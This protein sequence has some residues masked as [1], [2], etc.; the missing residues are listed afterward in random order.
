MNFIL[1]N[2][3]AEDP[4][5][6]FHTWKKGIARQPAFLDDYS[7]LV[8]ALIHLQEITG[9]PGY[10]LKAKSITEFVIDN[11][12]EPDTGYFYFTSHN[13][14]DV[15]VRKKEVYDGAQPS[16]NAVMAENLYRLSFYFDISLWKKQAFRITESLGKAIINYPSSFGAWSCLYLEM[17]MGTNE[18]VVIENENESL[19]NQ[20]LV[21]Y[22]PH[23]ILKN[24]KGDEKLFP[25]MAEKN[26]FDKPAIYLC[27]NS[28]CEK[29]VETINELMGL[30]MAN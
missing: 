19:Y 30:I 28:A 12:S 27:R 7:F 6:F 25:I 21:K 24:S 18:I 1:K 17:V 5:E 22:I 8:Q 2:Y 29:P 9:E 14:K 15:I 23:K 16:G 3:T 11:F 4:D 10:L 13:Q 20:L 26:Y